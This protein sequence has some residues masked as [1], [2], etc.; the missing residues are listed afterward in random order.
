MPMERVL[1]TATLVITRMVDPPG[2]AAF[3]DLASEHAVQF[4]RALRDAA[5]ES[6]ES[7]LRLDCAGLDTVSVEGLNAVADA[8]ADL[9]RTGRT[10]I[11]FN[12]SP[13][14]HRIFR[15]TGWD[16]TPGLVLDG[17]DEPPASDAPG[18]QRQRTRR[19]LPA[20]DGS[21]DAVA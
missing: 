18:P 2:L 10:L 14:F 21:S 12:L 7:N 1:D 3:G 4:A 20:V 8:A 5:A 15:L 9:S 19:A 16:E 17:A 11:V 13:Y 6:P